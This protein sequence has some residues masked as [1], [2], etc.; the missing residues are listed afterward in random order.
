MPPDSESTYRRS[1]SIQ[2][3]GKSVYKT[4][5]INDAVAILE[6]HSQ[7]P[8]IQEIREHSLKKS[9]GAFPAMLA[10]HAIKLYAISRSRPK[11]KYPCRTME[12]VSSAGHTYMQDLLSC[13]QALSDETFY[14]SAGVQ[15][16]IKENTDAEQIGATRFLGNLR[17]LPDFPNPNADVDDEW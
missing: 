16:L 11:G 6:R 2:A 17:A 10:R 4:A 7:D 3:H 14:N 8:V 15:Y 5:H 9:N 12:L 1:V 13:G